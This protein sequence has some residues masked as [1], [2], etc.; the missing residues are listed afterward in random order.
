M[1]QV[2]CWPAASA[3]VVGVGG[4]TLNLNS[5]GTV[6]SETAW[7]ESSG[8]VSDYVPRPAYQTNFG[9]TIR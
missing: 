6:I 8:G 7:S 5:D 1:A 3:N 4:T 2:Y 9:L